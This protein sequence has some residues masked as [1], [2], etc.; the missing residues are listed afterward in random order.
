MSEKGIPA[1]AEARLMLQESEQL[2]PGPWVQHSLYAAQAAKLIAENCPG[3][4]PEKAYILGLLHDIGRRAG[5]T[6][7]RHSIDG[8]TYL[9]EKGYDA[10]GKI[11]LTHSFPLKNIKEAFGSWDCTDEEYSMAEDF[12]KKVEYD[13]Y[14]KLIQ[15]CDALALPGGYTLMEKRMIDVALRHG[16]HEYTVPKW[17]ATFEI[18]NY[19]ESLMGKSIYSVL[20]GV[21]ENTFKL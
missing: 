5:V 1:L 2:N 19:F 12:L 20:P 14:D 4:N 11:C 3:L 21:I 13:D 16:V 15:L 8:Y 18:K 9:R 7:M 6:N 10:A 17:K